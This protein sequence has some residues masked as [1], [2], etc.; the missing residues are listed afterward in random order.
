MH[1]IYSPDYLTANCT[2]CII[3]GSFTSRISVQ[4][5]LAVTFPS[6]LAGQVGLLLAVLL[7][8][9][10]FFC[11][12]D[13]CPLQTYTLQALLHLAAWLASAVR[14]VLSRPRSRRRHGARQPRCLCGLGYCSR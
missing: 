7:L 6:P 12:Y 14:T 5:G 10:P 3:R 1:M 8:P 11:K 4:H 13:K 2:M 9:F